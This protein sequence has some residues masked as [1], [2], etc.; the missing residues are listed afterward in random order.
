MRKRINYLLP[1]YCIIILWI[2]EVLSLNRIK[3]IIDLKGT[4]QSVV[5][6][7]LT[8]ACNYRCSYCLRSCTSQQNQD[9]SLAKHDYKIALESAPDIARIINEMPGK[10]KLDLIGGEVSLFDL[11]FAFLFKFYF[12]SF[13]FNEFFHYFTI[14]IYLEIL[15]LIFFI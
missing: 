6:W 7:R 4:C 5:K 13:L 8:D 15:F 3:T 10:V 9:I 11:Q 2:K 12:L 14:C 1:F